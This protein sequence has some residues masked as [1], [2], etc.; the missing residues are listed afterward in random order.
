MFNLFLFLK[1]SQISVT[2]SLLKAHF[3]FIWVFELN[4]KCMSRNETLNQ[5]FQLQ[6]NHKHLIR[7]LVSRNSQAE[8]LIETDWSC[9]IQFVWPC[10]TLHIL[11]N[12]CQKCYMYLVFAWWVLLGFVYTPAFSYQT[13]GGMQKIKKGIP[14]AKVYQMGFYGLIQYT[15]KHH[16]WYFRNRYKMNYNCDHTIESPAY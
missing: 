10:Y 5:N 9:K 4:I 16:A 7:T 6:R 2:H 13:R 1:I 15:L 12:N 14:E 3:S 11:H 8:G